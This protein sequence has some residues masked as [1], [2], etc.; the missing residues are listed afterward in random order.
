MRQGMEKAGSVYK[1]FLAMVLMLC[2]FCAGCGRE[3]TGEEPTA[4]TAESTGAS[5]ALTTE[6]T[7]PT[8]DLRSRMGFYV[9]GAA[10]Y[11][12]NG[13]P[14][15][16]RGVNHAHTWFPNEMEVTAKALAAAGC[17][18]VRVVL[19]NGEVW[20]RNEA[21]EVSRIIELCK[22]NNLIAV[23]EVHDT[24]GRQDIAAAMAAAEYFVSIKDALLGEEAYVILNIANEWP[25]SADSYTWKS[26]YLEAIPYLREAGLA[27]TIMVDCSGGGQNGR[28]ME[29][30]GEA[31]LASD[32]L[33][34]V[35]FSIH[36][37]AKS[38]G[39]AALVEKN[40]RYGTDL[41]LCVCV[42][43]FGYQHDGKDV[44]EAFIMAYCVENDIGYLAWSWKGNAE[45]A[46][47]LDLALDWE[48]KQLS[49]DW[50]ETVI[51]G[52][53]GI[54][55]TAIICSVFTDNS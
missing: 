48:G 15:V 52:P 19:S 10:L 24:T 29:L 23:L 43:E 14:F 46:A 7:E 41:D 21:E 38:G 33:K 45:Q 55:E 13:N 34:N 51:N 31:V 6:A 25:S 3:E 28:C 50:G 36:L 44:D 18:C 42:G 16:M 35:M 22:E 20:E 11:D 53:N 26:A 8:E 32:P 5:T 54:R 12:A 27:H 17:N 40:I 30:G 1:R 47:Y 39:N 49:A 37:Y 2:L 9:V 4:V